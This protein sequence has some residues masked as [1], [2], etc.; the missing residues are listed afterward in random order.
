LLESCGEVL[1]PRRGSGPQ[2]ERAID[3]HPG[4]GGAGAR[5]HLGGRIERAA[6][7]VS[8][9]HAHDRPIV[10]RRQRVR[11]HPS[12]AVHGD[13]MHPIA[14][15]TQQAERLQQRHVHLVADDDGQRRRAEQDR[16]ARRPTH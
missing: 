7:H 5:A 15:E 12:L 16:R 1:V 2:T 11:A 14:A 13:A 3:V 4:A 9:L 8:R 6:V 10:E